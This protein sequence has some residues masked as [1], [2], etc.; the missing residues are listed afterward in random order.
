MRRN[1]IMERIIHGAASPAAIAGQRH[2]DM[3]PCITNRVVARN[4]VT[5]FDVAQ[6]A[7]VSASAYTAAPTTESEARA[8][9]GD[10]GDAVGRDRFAENRCRA[11]LSTDQVHHSLQQCR[12]G[13]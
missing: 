9:N 10:D 6:R 13:I 3:A 1:L 11:G 7:Y 2:D 12:G 4:A 8:R 5:D